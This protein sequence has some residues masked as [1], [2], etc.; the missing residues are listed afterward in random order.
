[1]VVLDNLAPHTP[2]EVR[3][4]VE[5]RGARLQFLPP[6][7]PDFNPIELAFAKLKHSSAPRDRAP[8]TKSSS[9][10]RSRW[11]C[12][13]QE[14]AGISS[15]IAATEYLHGNEN[16]HGVPE[17]PYKARRSKVRAGG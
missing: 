8:S 10:S 3:A 5:R 2:A 12:A 4:A 16:A 15:G 14:N 17:N 1:V 13:G 9:S 11:S 6:Y 7:S